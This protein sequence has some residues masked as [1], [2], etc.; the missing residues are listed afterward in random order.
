[1]FREV[2]IGLL[3]FTAIDAAFAGQG[4]NE[5]TFT[6]HAEQIACEIHQTQFVSREVD[7]AF[8]NVK[9]ANARF[10]KI[11]GTKPGLFTSWIDDDQ[12]QWRAW[13]AEDCRLQGEVTMGTAGADVTQECL[14]DGYLQRIRSLN[15]LAR[16]LD[17]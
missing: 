4:C 6:S 10:E 5:A 11:P 3:A 8:A 14:Q 16:T 17:P 1:M 7:A 2:L 13:I 9:V 15:Q 12:K